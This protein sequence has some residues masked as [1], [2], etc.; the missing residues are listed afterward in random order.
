VRGAPAAAAV[1]LAVALGVARPARAE[2]AAVLD[3]TLEGCPQ[4]DEARLRELFVIELGTV[5]P[6]GARDVDVRLVCDGA[7]VA[8]ELRDRA[9]GRSWR[10][11]VD[12][13]ATPEATRLRLLVLAVTEQWSLERAPAATATTPPPSASPAGVPVVAASPSPPAPPQWRLDARA[14]ARRAGTP[15]L[16]LGG[17]GV[18][19]ERG[20]GR[21]LGL[22]LDVAAEAGEVS[23]SV[24]RVDVRE[25]VASAS[26]RAT[27]TAGRWSLGAGPGFNVGLASLAGTPFAAGATGGTLDAAWAGPTLGAR[28]RVALGR[29]ISVVAD[30]GGGYTTRRVTGLVDD[31]ATLLQLGG[32]WLALG[33][34]AGWSF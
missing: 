2:G 29:G 16:W 30:V 4:I 19:V 8:V 27:A 10:A 31:R 28:A 5:R 21:H 26:L 3:L 25:V 6:S 18:G 13:A 17:A 7:R 32:P 9:L 20:L 34:G 33:L 12:L 1:V 24:A 15:G 14:V 22:A 11:D 23:T